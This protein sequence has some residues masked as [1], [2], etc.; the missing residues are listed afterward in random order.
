MMR[1]AARIL[2]RSL[3]AT[4]EAAMPGVL[5]GEVKAAYL[6]SIFADGADMP[7]N[8]PIFNSG[9]RAVFGR[10]LSSPRRIEAQDQL[11]VEYPVSYRRYNVKT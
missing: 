9:E 5:E 7:P 3:I 1:E 11:L 4:I 6:A 10:G 8:D 2:D